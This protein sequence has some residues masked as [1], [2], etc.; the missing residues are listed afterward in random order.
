MRNQSIKK[1]PDCL[2]K[3]CGILKNN[4]IEITNFE[5]KEILH[6]SFKD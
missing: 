6:L 3:F 1:G 2:D 4:S 5:H